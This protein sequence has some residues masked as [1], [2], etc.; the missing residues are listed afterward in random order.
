MM[1]IFKKNCNEFKVDN[2][3]RKYLYDISE[4]FVGKKINTDKSIK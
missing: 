4:R 1:N 2:D 3:I